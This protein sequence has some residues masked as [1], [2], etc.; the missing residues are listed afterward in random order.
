VY[1][2]FLY[3]ILL[4]SSTATA[5]AIA[6]ASSIVVVVVVVTC[7]RSFFASNVAVSLKLFCCYRIISQRL[8]VANKYHPGSCCCYHTPLWNTATSF[9]R[10]ISMCPKKPVYP[11]TILHQNCSIVAQLR[12]PCATLSTQILVD[13]PRQYISTAST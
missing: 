7:G 10:H 3:V 12:R 2:L 6:V 11:V 9:P 8:I 1:L 13:I 4:N 5:F